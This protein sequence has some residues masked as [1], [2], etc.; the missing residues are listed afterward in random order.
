M[1]ANLKR[2]MPDEETA[3]EVAIDALIWLSQK[4]DLME[5]FL[6]LTGIYADAIRSMIGQRSF[7]A[8]LLTFIA[9]KDQT[10]S[11]FCWDKN[12]HPDWVNAC[13]EH[14]SSEIEI[15]WT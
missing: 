14:F 8:E 11:D 15:H 4:L 1:L 6:S 2:E 9:Y 7:Y 5:R 3:E 13:R 10:L 12:Y